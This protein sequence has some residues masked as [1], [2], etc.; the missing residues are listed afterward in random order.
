MRKTRITICALLGLLVCSTS[1]LIGMQNVNAAT[2]GA[3]IFC[4]NNWSPEPPPNGAGDTGPELWLSNMSCYYIWSY[5]KAEYDGYCLWFS[6]DTVPPN[7]PSN[8]TVTSSTYYNTLTL[9]ENTNSKV[10]VFSKGHC[11]PWGNGVHYKLLCTD[12]PD[13][14]TDNNIFLST[15]QAKCRFDFIWH[16]GTAQS[17]PVAPPYQDNYGYIGMPLAFTHRVDMTKYGSSGPCVYVGWNWWSPRFIDPIPQNP[18]WQWAQFAVGIFYYKHYNGWSLGYTLDTMANWIYGSYD[19]LSSPLYN[20]LVVW[21]NMNM[22][23]S[24]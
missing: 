16:C 5:L 15:N 19:F 12:N 2:Y 7:P 20:D 9:L 22:H 8:P 13:A 4:P 14:A 21:G 17:Y 11:V 23:L 24:Y 3:G 1:L 18:N 6:G 10:T